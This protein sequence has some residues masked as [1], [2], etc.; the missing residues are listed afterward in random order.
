MRKAK[1]GEIVHLRILPTKKNSLLHTEEDIQMY[2]LLKKVYLDM[3]QQASARINSKHRE[4]L[5][6][7]R[8]WIIS[9]TDRIKDTKK[10]AYKFFHRI[11]WVFNGLKD[12]PH[13]K[14]CGKKIGEFENFKCFSPFG[15]NEYCCRRCAATSEE[16]RR[17]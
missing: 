5:F 13:C 12:F 14:T 3:P 6:S 9:K 10:F 8:E 2:E 1:T 4:D 7:L 11:V 15:Y 16:V 17:R